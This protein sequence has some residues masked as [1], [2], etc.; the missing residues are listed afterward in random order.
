MYSVVLKELM[1]FKTVTISDL[2]S[3]RT[4]LIVVLNSDNP[5]VTGEIS[6]KNKVL[7]PMP[8]LPN[9]DVQGGSGT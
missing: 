3:K 4:G 5:L 8:D 9:L 2:F 6:L 1:S 7:S